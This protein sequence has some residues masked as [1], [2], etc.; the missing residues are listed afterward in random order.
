MRISWVLFAV[1]VAACDTLA[2]PDA[3]SGGRLDMMW[4]EDA[5]AGDPDAGQGDPDAAQ[6][7][8]DAAQ[9]EPDAA[10]PEPDAAAGPGNASV[11][12]GFPEGAFALL[13]TDD[14]EVRAGMAKDDNVGGEP[15]MFVKDF[16][17]TPQ[18][19]W[20][21]ARSLVRFDLSSLGDLDPQSISEVRVAM[22]GNVGD[23]SF[24]NPDAAQPIPIQLWAVPDDDD[25]W[26]QGT[27]TWNTQPDRR[28][29]QPVGSISFTHACGC[30]EYFQDGGD[31]E[32]S[33][34]L[35]AEVT[36][37][38]TEGNSVLTLRMENP[39]MDEAV[40]YTREYNLELAPRLVFV[41]AE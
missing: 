36:R 41:L 37:E 32:R 12:E 13:A 25:D 9:P 8:P 17:D 31:W 16:P 39:I 38:L 35:A 2:G 27:V 21:F 6:G 28:G 3:G 24:G 30:F 11:P 1:A 14:A 33:T 22:W 26:S 19:G 23:A 4:E 34:D 29:D 20:A 40:V 10:Q 18:D 5:G 15:I 7:D